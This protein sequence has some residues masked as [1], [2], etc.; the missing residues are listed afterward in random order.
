MN[1]EYEYLMW[2][3]EHILGYCPDESAWLPT[4]A[5][6]AYLID[7]KLPAEDI[8]AELARHNTETIHPNNLS[9]IL[10]KGSLLQKGHFYFHKELQIQ[11][12]APVLKKDGSISYADDYLEMKIR[13]SEQ[14]VLDYFYCRLSKQDRLL[15]EPKTDTKTVQYI[16][17]R[18]SN[19][20]YVEPVD[21]LLCL[22]D[23][24]T[25]N[26]ENKNNE[27]LVSVLSSLQNVL[28][29]YQNDVR[30][31]AAASQ[32]RIRWRYGI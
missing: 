13:Y 28:S 5:S 32:N 2:Y 29:W 10:W 7:N 14:D 21:L 4:R 25:N 9:D 26:E 18:F 12:P 6:I 27:G 22:I 24:Y 20:E 11:S 19:V 23:D 31:A 15:C 16:I 8:V 3:F 1:P 30:N 17:K